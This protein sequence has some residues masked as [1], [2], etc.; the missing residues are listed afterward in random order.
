MVKVRGLSSSMPA[1]V[2]FSVSHSNCRLVEGE[3][4]DPG[5]PDPLSNMFTLLTARRNRALTQQ[6]GVWLAGKDAER[7]LKVSHH[8]LL[9]FGAF[10]APGIISQLSTSHGSAKRG[11]KAEDE[12]ATL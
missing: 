2:P 5:I 4:V 1:F 3:W 8:A 10:R 6:W 9:F 7:A 11:Q 12:A